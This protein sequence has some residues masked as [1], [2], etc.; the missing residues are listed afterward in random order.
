MIIV[1]VICLDLGVVGID[2][3]DY[4]TI[5]TIVKYSI[6]SLCEQPLFRVLYEC[7]VDYKLVVL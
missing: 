5:D 2:Y 1:K 4:L 7:D 6:G 3:L